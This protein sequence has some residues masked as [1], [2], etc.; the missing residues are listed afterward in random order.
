M[1]KSQGVAMEAIQEGSLE[2]TCSR[3]STATNEQVEIEKLKRE[4]GKLKLENDKLKSTKEAK[5]TTLQ[6]ELDRLN[7]EN[8][9]LKDHKSLSET[10]RRR[11][12]RLEHQAEIDTQ[13][14]MKE[15]K[16][17]VLKGQALDLAFLVDATGSM[18]STINMVKEQIKEMAAGVKE[19]YPDVKLRVAFVAYR[20]YEDDLVTEKC[21]FTDQLSTF[22]QALSE[23]YANGGGDQA[24]DVFSGL[25]GIAS[26]NWTSQNRLLFH[27]ADAPCHGLR[28]HNGVTDNFPAGD[29]F[30]RRIED[31]LSSL[32]T[33]CKITKYFFC[34]LNTSTEKMVRE[35]KN[36]DD[37]I[38][39]WIQ[40]ELFSNINKIPHVV[41]T[42][43]RMTIQKTMSMV[44]VADITVKYVPEV[45]KNEQPNWESIATL[46][47]QKTKHIRYSQVNEMLDKIRTKQSLELEEVKWCSVQI[48]Q[49]P[50]SSEGSIRW[51]YY[52]QVATVPGQVSSSPMVVKRFKTPFGKDVREL[53]K[54]EKYFEQM[55]VQ[56]VSAHMATEFNKR[57]RNLPGVKM[58]EFTEVSVLEVEG[59]F[60][61]MEMLLLG[62]W[63]K[64]N[65]NGG[66]INLEEYRATLQAFTHWTYEYS[67]KLLMVTDLQGVLAPNSDG[68]MRF[69]LCDPAIHCADVLRFTKTNLGPEGFKLFFNT[70]KCNDVCRNLKLKPGRNGVTTSGTIVGC[71]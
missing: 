60:Y 35:F 65:N 33:N 6:K 40:Q 42:M 23:L 30:G 32:R 55:E 8:D 68:H 21:E 69:H 48:A 18:Q 17:L 3:S 12:S 66:F 71:S 58:V 25:E 51:P 45:V 13:K 31:L 41:V 36:A 43:C 64:Y 10:E 52:A 9:K 63:I 34:H 26:L 24:E 39:D 15:I 16:K 59:N 14:R 49:N 20:D 50:F 54:K 70:H 67:D 61:N 1:R 27:I 7:R 5:V 22:T 44:G 62:K 53:H 4:L 57:I 28:F 38:G 11:L 47:G 37:E 46:Q 56:T 2:G 29:K 19:A